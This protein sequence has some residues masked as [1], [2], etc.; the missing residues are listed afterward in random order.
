MSTAVQKKAGDQV[1]RA[2]GESERDALKRD[3]AV[4]EGRFREVEKRKQAEIRRAPRRLCNQREEVAKAR[5]LTVSAFSKDGEAS[6]ICCTSNITQKTAHKL[7]YVALD[8][9]CCDQILQPVDFRDVASFN[10]LDVDGR[11]SKIHGNGTFS[12]KGAS[13]GD[14]LLSVLLPSNSV[15]KGFASRGGGYDCN[16]HVMHKD[17]LGV[18]FIDPAERMRGNVRACREDFKLSVLRLLNHSDDPNIAISTRD[19]ATPAW[20]E[21]VGETFPMWYECMLVA[22]RRIKVDEELTIQYAVAPKGVKT[23]KR[24]RRK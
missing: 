24:K 9:T 3:I 14:V 19:A 13:K 21:A 4:L 12:K 2:K 10:D 20:Y 16:Q 7:M 1:E 22:R 18:M 23:A 11:P 6:C 17:G 5:P 15:E 8:L